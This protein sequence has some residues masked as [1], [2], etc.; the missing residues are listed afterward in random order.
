MKTKK[1]SII[2]F[3][4]SLAFLSL[5]PTW[6]NEG[7]AKDQ[8]VIS[9]LNQEL[10]ETEDQLLENSLT[11]FF[12]DEKADI[13]RKVVLEEGM[14]EADRKEIKQMINSSKLV[15]VKNQTYFYLKSEKSSN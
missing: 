14:S 6:A 11:L 1:L 8:K 3:S 12:I 10:I 2:L 5:Q 4:I 15:M 7:P 9:F 13:Q